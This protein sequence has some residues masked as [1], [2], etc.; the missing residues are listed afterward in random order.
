MSHVPTT[1]T[2]AQIHDSDFVTNSIHMFSYPYRG[3]ICDSDI[4]D[5]FNSNVLLAL[6]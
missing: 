5:K 1:H 4:D 6:P 3:P 2:V